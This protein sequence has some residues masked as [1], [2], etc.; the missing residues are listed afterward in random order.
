MSDAKTPLPAEALNHLDAL[1]NLARWLARDPT[2]AEDL[3]QETYLRAI[4]AAHQFQPGTNLRAW[5]FQI[6][7]NTFFTRYK[8]KGREPEVMDPEV[9]DRMS[10]LEGPTG[11][12]N[13]LAGPQDGTA[14]LD[15][16]AALKR[17]PEAYRSVVLLADVEDFS[18]GE[19]ARIM[20]CPVGTVKSRLF[21]ARAIL[22]ELL[23]DYVS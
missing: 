20:D 17:L 9:L 22:K 8:R 1:Y 2:E 10:T 16:T 5:L 3:V 6:L 13:R 19:I 7:R 12:E 18:M 4:R 23:R 14:G 21:R 11:V 15:L